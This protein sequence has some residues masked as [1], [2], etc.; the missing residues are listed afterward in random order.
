MNYLSDRPT[1]NISNKRGEVDSVG[2]SEKMKEMEDE[3]KKQ[4]EELCTLRQYG[5]TPPPKGKGKP[6]GKKGGDN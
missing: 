1:P 2:E 5:W 4:E 3:I 6:K